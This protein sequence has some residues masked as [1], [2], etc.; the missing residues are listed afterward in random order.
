MD[1]IQDGRAASSVGKLIMS[2]TEGL[3]LLA[4]DGS[5]LNSSAHLV[6]RVLIGTLSL[7]IS[8]ELS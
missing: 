3:G 1:G 4:R 2:D 5:S 6:I 8:N 7:M